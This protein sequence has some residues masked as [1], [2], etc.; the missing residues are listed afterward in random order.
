MCTEE[1]P[2]EV[3]LQ[4]VQRL[5]LDVNAVPY[6]PTLFSTQNPPK[7]VSIRLLSLKKS[8]TAPELN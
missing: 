1:V 6:V 4:R 3:A 8:A 2:D 7:P 5:L